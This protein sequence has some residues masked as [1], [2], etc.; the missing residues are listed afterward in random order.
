MCQPI[1][2]LR[3]GY[4]ERKDHKEVRWIIS[5]DHLINTRSEMDG[6]GVDYLTSA[7]EEM[8][9]NG[10]LE[11]D[12]VDNFLKTLAIAKKNASMK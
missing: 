1:T 8:G 9:T 4:Q 2:T 3:K 11:K 6:I 5:M 10:G 7:L 12:Y